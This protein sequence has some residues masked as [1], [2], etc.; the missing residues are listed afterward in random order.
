MPSTSFSLKEL[1]VLPNRVDDVIGSVP[2]PPPP[3]AVK[4]VEII[5][6]LNISSSLLFYSSDVE[7]LLFSYNNFILDATI[8]LLENWLDIGLASSIL[9][10]EELLIVDVFVLVKLYRFIEDE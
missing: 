2:V 5:D 6:L 7:M 9:D 10:E 8:F 3:L 1:I 4:L